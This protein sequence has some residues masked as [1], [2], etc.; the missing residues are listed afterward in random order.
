MG[1]WSSERRRSDS[2]CPGPRFITGTRELMEFATAKA[3]HAVSRKQNQMQ[4]S[5]RKLIKEN[6]LAIMLSVSKRTVRRLRNSRVI[7]F[8]KLGRGIIRYCPE[9]CHSA[10][11]HYRVQTQTELRHSWS[12]ESGAPLLLQT[13]ERAKGTRGDKQQRGQSP[14]RTNGDYIQAKEEITHD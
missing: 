1:R 2:I 7:P 6:E 9:Q 4:S 10:L 14:R 3:I 11:E 12:P 5:E 8:Y 13:Q